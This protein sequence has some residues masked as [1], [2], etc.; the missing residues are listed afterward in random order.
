M[1]V[2]KNETPNTHFM[3]KFVQNGQPCRS[4]IRNTGLCS[5][6]RRLNW[7][8]AEPFIYYLFIYCLFWVVYLPLGCEVGP[9]WNEG[10]QKKVTLLDYM[11]CFD[12]MICNFYAPP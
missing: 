5:N 9:L 11:L 1:G 6:G 4:V 12:K 3:L 8:P 7:E 10:L 2:F